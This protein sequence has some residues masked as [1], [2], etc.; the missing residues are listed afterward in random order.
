MSPPANSPSATGIP[1]NSSLSFSQNSCFPRVG[2]LICGAY[3]EN[4]WNTNLPSI[5]LIFIL[6][7]CL[8]TSITFSAS[9]FG[10][11]TYAIATR[12]N[13]TTR[14]CIFLH[15]F[16]KQ[17]TLSNGPLAGNRCPW[18]LATPPLS[19]DSLPLILHHSQCLV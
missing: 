12:V 13:N 10:D 9:L 1:T 15:C 8:S 16:P 14:F 7:L 11:Y 17:Y 19:N 4:I 5:I 18:F 2:L 6:S 3:T